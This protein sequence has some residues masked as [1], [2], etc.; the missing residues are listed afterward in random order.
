MSQGELLALLTQRLGDSI[1]T[2]S[3]ILEAARTDRS[4]KISSARPLCVV[5]VTSTQQ[6][7]E[8]LSI[9]N[10]TSTPVVTRGGGSG[11]AGG[12]IGDQGEI[13]LS[14]TK[15]NKILQIS[16]TDRFAIVQAGVI[17]Q[18]LNL[19][20][21]EKGLWFAPDPASRQWSTVGGNIATNAGGLLCAKYGVTR[22]SVRELTV[23]LADGEI[24]TLGHQTVKGVT[25]YDLASLFVGS[26]GTLGVITEAKVSLK[27]ADTHPVWTI[28][29]VAKTIREAGL[30]IQK[31]IEAGLQPSVFELV[32]EKCAKYIEKYLSLETTKFSGNRLI[33]QT[34]GSGAQDMAREIESVWRGLGLDVELQLDGETLI[35]FR[36][37]M[38][39]A[40]EASGKV[41][42]EDVAVPISA[43]AEMLVAIRE[44]ESEF[45]INIPTVA[46]AG[47]GNLHPNFLYTEDEVPDVIWRAADALFRKAVD[48]GGTL[49]GEHGV[50]LLKRQW[51]MEELGE[52]QWDLQWRIKK[53][54]DPNLILNPGKVFDP[55]HLTATKDKLV[56]KPLK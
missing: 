15:M 10:S 30:A 26:E 39:P 16:T 20:A 22:D 7:S 46:H 54:F 38:L 24:M 42:I 32:D 47:D 23:V 40:L 3:E 25:G 37:A 11:L 44:V 53:L 49:T 4:G 17:N 51:L 28:S 36:R 41:L 29:A 18:D 33:A 52:S 1:V 56:K 48:L 31:T 8:L 50:G 34:D 55:S 2:D 12:A 27:P 9:A 19:A 5:E 35:G 6:V 13:V 43:I 14:M 21:Q 45:G